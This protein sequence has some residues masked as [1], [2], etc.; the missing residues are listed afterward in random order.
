MI[1]FFLM[2]GAGL[3]CQDINP[4]NRGVLHINKSNSYLFLESDKNFNCPTS[5]LKVV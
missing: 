1:L 4:D 2:P 5:K 3:S